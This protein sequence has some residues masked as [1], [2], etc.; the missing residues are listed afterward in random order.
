MGVSFVEDN[1]AS[2]RRLEALVTRLSDDDLSRTTSYGWTVA[3]LLAHLAFWDQ[4]V[5][6]LL[7]RWKDNGVDESPVDSQALNDALR[8]L[9]IAMD[10]R[11]SIR[12]CLTSARDVDAELE[13]IS[14]SLLERS[15]NSA[16]PTQ[17]ANRSP[18]RPSRFSMPQPPSLPTTRDS[19]RHSSST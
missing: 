17:S 9:L 11:T 18:R 15:R 4:R 2:R 7:R 8:P 1:A 14:P 12:L 6:V 10:P 16:L 3:A 13:N 5:L 19:L